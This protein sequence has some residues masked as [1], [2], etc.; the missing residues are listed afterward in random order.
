M[1]KKTEMSLQAFDPSAG[2][3]DRRVPIS[4]VAKICARRLDLKFPLSPPRTDPK[5]VLKFAWVPVHKIFINYER[6]RWPEPSHM[7]K[8]DGK[9]DI[10]CVTP[11]QCRYDPVEDRYYAADGQQHMIVWLIQYG[12]T[13]EIPCFYVESTDPVIESIQLLALNT[14][15]KP[16]AKYF[17]H[18]QKCTMKDPEALAIEAAVVNANCQTSYWKKQAGCI[19]HISHLYD[20]SENYGNSALESILCRYRNFWPHDKIDMVTVL[21]FLKLYDMLM[22]SNCYD[23]STFNDCFYHVRTHYDSGSEFIQAVAHAFRTDYPTNHKGMGAREKVA[24]SI[25]SVYEQET[26]NKL[27]DQPFAITIN[28]MTGDQPVS[29]EDLE[30]EEVL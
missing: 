5:T 4:D 26:G 15:S 16:M 30:D 13:A 21:G 22:T 23:E 3:R 7:K 14:D 17:I 9:W 8:L 25:I 18:K 20:A 1:S 11:L 19:T 6:Q 10:N 24:S 27:I 2:L 28:V 12:L 29:E